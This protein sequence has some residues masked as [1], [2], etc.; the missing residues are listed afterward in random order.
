VRYLVM[1]KTMFYIGKFIKKL[2]LKYN[3]YKVIYIFF[4]LNFIKYC[5]FLYFKSAFEKIEFFLFFLYF[6]LNFFG[7]FSLFWCADI[8]NNFLIIIIIYYFNVFSSKKHF[9]K[10]SQSHNYQTCYTCFLLRINFNYN[11]YQTRI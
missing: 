9:E 8:K 1:I 3:F 6:K 11:F 7:V 10:Q 2:S 5:L 4:K